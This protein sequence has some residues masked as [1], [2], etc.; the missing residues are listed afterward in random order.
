MSMPLSCGRPVGDQL[1]LIMT[2]F[3]ADKWHYMGGVRMED[4]QFKQLMIRLD[5]ITKLLAASLPQEMTL[6]EKTLLLHG[7]GLS[8]TQIASMIGTTPAYVGTALARARKAKRK[9]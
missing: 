9:T 4:R 6:T 3:V 1:V 7:V 5:T 8:S 2:S